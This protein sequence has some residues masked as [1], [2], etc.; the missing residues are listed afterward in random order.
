MSLVWVNGQPNTGVSPLDRGLAYG[1]GLFATMR[2]SAQGILYL[3]AHLN[4]LQQGAARLGLQHQEMP[5]T[6]SASTIYLLKSLASNYPHHCIKLL[7]SRG[8]GGR[9]YA[10]P[11]DG[12]VTEIISVSELPPM[13]QD[14][15][16]TGI[17]LAT[18]LVTLGHQPLLAGMKHLNRLEQVLIK[19][20]PLPQGVDD[21][22]VND[23]DGNAIE[24][25]MANIFFI[26]QG[27]CF[28]PS[29]TRCGVAGVMREQVIAALLSRGIDV[30]CVDFPY[31]RLLEVQHVFISNS[32]FGLVDVN[33]ID[34]LAFSPWPY[35]ADIRQQ[36]AVDL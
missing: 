29:L 31:Q 15:Q 35:T 17:Q 1:D 21:W 5:W 26:D 23:F 4:R 3:E 32:L 11:K 13:Y 34:D 9:G 28:T 10:P 8:V 33:C 7:L 12:C 6:A 36:L 22:L 18:S 19:S 20:R 24:A 30:Q 14:W 27:Q 25:S 2:S 16:Q